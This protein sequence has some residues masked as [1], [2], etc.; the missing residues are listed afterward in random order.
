MKVIAYIGASILIFFGVMFIWSAFGTTPQ[1]ANIGIGAVTL[2]IG[3]AIIWFTQRKS[4]AAAAEQNI[5][6]NVDLPGEIKLETMKCQAC[7]GALTS[8][9]IEMQSGAPMIVCPY[10]ETTYQL[11]EEPKW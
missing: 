9:N 6:V 2:A 7:G 1:P 11:N 3:F 5:S 4:K 8:K 10:C